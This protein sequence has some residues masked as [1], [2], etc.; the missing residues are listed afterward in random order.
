MN[1]KTVKNYLYNGF[2]F[3][4]LLRKAEMRKVQGKWLLQID[5]ENAAEMLIKALPNKS[6]GLSGAEIRFIRTYFNL[7][8]RK[9]ADELNVSHT[10]VNKW[11]D[12][13]QEKANIESHIEFY[14][15][16]YVKLKLDEEKNIA[17]SFKTLLEDSKHFGDEAKMEPVC[18]PA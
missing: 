1:R 2:G 4:V 6:A 15:R 11:E 18:L 12:A 16:A 3:P 13:D 14:L 9:F 7:S 5:V 10:A 17:E 8:K